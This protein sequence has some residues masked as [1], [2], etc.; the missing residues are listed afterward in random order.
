[1]MKKKN[2]LVTGGAGFIGSNLVEELL[3]HP[4]VGTVRV[5]DNFSTGFRRNVDPFMEHPSFELFEGDIRD[6]DACLSACRNMDLI[7]HQAALGSVPRSIQDPVTSTDVN[8]SGTVNIFTAAREN[9]IRRVIYAASSSTYGDSQGLPKV[10][11]TIGKPLSPYAIT[12]YVMELYA[13]VYA[14][15]YGMEFI[16]LRYFNV[17]GPR[18]D[19]NGAY[20]AVIP[21]FFSS[22]L[23]GKPATINGDG[24]YS[25]DFTYVENAVQAN[26]LS[27][28]TTNPDAVN[29][30]YNIACGER[31]TLNELW[32]LICGVLGIEMPAI[33]GPARSG[34][35]PHSLADV[36]KAAN[37]L[38]YV[39]AVHVKVGLEKASG[40]YK[41]FL[42]NSGW[43]D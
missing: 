28:F 2:I 10:E 19:P 4:S 17:F 25:R 21:L 40:W 14:R 9:G 11:H 18:Q 32:D 12:K 26:L 37:R 39:P 27:L 43:G 6:F 13:D 29:Q 31:T 38:N 30:V 33:H 22:A 24:K 36:S 1:M 8:I 23:S 16:G 7:S 42:K 20:A 35:I 34:D 3:D 15:L 41:S 5:M